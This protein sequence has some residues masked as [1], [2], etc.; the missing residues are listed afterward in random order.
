MLWFGSWLTGGEGV[1]GEWFYSGRGGERASYTV[2]GRATGL[3]VRKW[4][5]EGLDAEYAD[6]LAFDGLGEV[7]PASLDFDTRQRFSRLA[8]HF[9]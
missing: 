3:R 9:E 6:V 8:P 5:N 2:P 7:A 1:E 4:P